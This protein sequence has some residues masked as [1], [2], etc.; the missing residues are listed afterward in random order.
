M[1]DQSQETNTEALPRFLV[2]IIVQTNGCFTSLTFRDSWLCGKKM[3][4]TDTDG[5]AGVGTPVTKEV[6]LGSQEKQFCN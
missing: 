2:H 6:M 1:E 5:E 3:T 4:G